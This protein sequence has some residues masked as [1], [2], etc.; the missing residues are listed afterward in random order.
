MKNFNK[1]SEIEPVTFRLVA[2]CL[3]QLYHCLPPAVAVA[4][5]ILV[6]FPCFLHCRD[7]QKYSALWSFQ[8]GEQARQWYR[9][10]GSYNIGVWELAASS[11]VEPF[12]T[13][14]HTQHVHKKTVAGHLAT[15]RHNPKETDL[16]QQFFNTNVRPNDGCG[17]RN[18]SP[19]TDKTPMPPGAF[20]P[21]SRAVNCTH[22]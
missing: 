22:T 5:T 11:S 19:T 8:D 21:A 6:L 10:L 9:R 12:A 17:W 15:Q 7:L 4:V 20:E 18:K 16:C 3:Y 14:W 1:P 2:Q 13:W